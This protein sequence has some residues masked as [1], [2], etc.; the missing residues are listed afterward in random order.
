MRP[1]ASRSPSRPGCSGPPRTGLG[2]VEVALDLNDAAYASTLAAE[3]QE[4]ARFYGTPGL[5]ARAAQSRGALLM[6]DHRAAEALEHLEQA[7][8]IYRHQRHRYAMARVHEQLADARQAMGENGTAAAE[9]AT[10]LAIY[11][12]LGAAPDVLRMTEG[13]RPCGLTEREVQVLTQVSAGLTNKEVARALV[14]SD[15]TEPA[16]VNIFTK[17]GVTSRTAA[18]AWARIHGVC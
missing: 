8:Q 9:R 2:L 11:R 1:C 17:T 7:A 13:N 6:T 12:R 5:V 4:T 16:P 18:A 14:I 10:A 15:K 3:L